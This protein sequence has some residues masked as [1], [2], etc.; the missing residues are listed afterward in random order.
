MK[1]TRAFVCL[2]VL[3]KS[4]PTTERQP[5]RER[6][7]HDPFVDCL[8]G[9]QRRPPRPR[10]RKLQSSAVDFPGIMMAIGLMKSMRG[11]FQLTMYEPR[12]HRS[13]AARL[14]PR[15]ALRDPHQPGARPLGR[16]L[17]SPTNFTTGF[18]PMM[19][20]E[21]PFRPAIPGFRQIFPCPKGIFSDYVHQRTFPEALARRSDITGEVFP[22]AG[23]GLPPTRQA[24]ASVLCV[25]AD[26][27]HATSSFLPRA[28]A[29]IR[30]TSRFLDEDDRFV[31]TRR[32]VDPATRSCSGSGI[33]VSTSFSRCAITV[34]REK[35]RSFAPRLLPQAHTHR[36]SPEFP[37]RSDAQ[38]LRR[39]VR[40]VRQACAE[41]EAKGQSWQSA[42]TA[43]AGGRARSGNR[44]R[45]RKAA[46][47]PTC[48][49]ST[50]ATEIASRRLS[51]RGCSRNLPRGGPCFAA[52]G[53][54]GACR[55]AS[56]CAGRVGMPRNCSGQIR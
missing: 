14:F 38:G 30:A 42:M 13:A 56:W 5:A 34:M 12:I 51:T 36:S 24:V 43:C 10:S 55:K 19:S 23:P 50:T 54:G 6:S 33:R 25:T 32:L 11:S 40:F 46:F 28:S 45:R 22:G 39:I 1:F 17:A 52:D 53:R 26:M 2:E 35:S 31:R 21:Q 15:A 20:S 41:A 3:L 44:S 4:C 27:T 48:G 16:G 18:A 47:N 8:P 37:G 49:P 9:S 7:S 29:C